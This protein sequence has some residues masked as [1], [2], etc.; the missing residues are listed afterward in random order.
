MEPH[1]EIRNQLEESKE[2]SDR[3]EYKLSN[4]E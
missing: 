3:K 1:T 2:K 4:L